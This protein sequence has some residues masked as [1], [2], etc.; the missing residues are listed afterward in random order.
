MNES[1]KINELFCTDYVILF[2][3]SKNELH[4]KVKS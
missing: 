2:A 4:N 1:V 3:K